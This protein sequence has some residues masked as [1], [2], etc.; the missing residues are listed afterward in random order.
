[1]L[2]FYVLIVPYIRRKNYSFKHITYQM[3]VFNTVGPHLG[4][5]HITAETCEQQTRQTM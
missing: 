1:M 5:E 3:L 2:Q 4:A